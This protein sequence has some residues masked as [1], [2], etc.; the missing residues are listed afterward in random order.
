V[1]SPKYDPQETVYRGILS[2]LRQAGTLAS[3]AGGNFGSADLIYG[4]DNMR[5]RKF[6]NSLRLRYAMRMGDRNA[7][8]ARTEFAA[9]LA[10]PGGVFTSNADNAM[11]R[12]VASRPNNNPLNEL[13]RTRYDHTVSKTLV[14]TLQAKRDPRLMVY[15]T[16]NAAGR[17]VGAPNGVIS[18]GVPFDSLS[19]IGAYFMAPD[20]PSMLMSYSEVLLLQAEAAA[21]GWTN[22]NAAE[23]Y[24]QAIRA[25]LSHYGVAEAQIA[26][27]L[28]SPAAQYNGLRSIHL[29]KWISLFGNGV[30]AWSEWRRTNVPVLT[31]GPR[32][33][34]SRRIPA[35]FPY[36]SIEQSVNNTNRLEAITRQNPGRTAITLNEL[37]WWDVARNTNQ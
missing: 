16:P 13:F 11:L 26:T 24:R 21:R 9:A 37:V 27:Y 3:Q 29:E 32:A 1:T 30:E 25:S 22:G 8:F 14:D 35:R 28:A 10:A 19:A 6:A 18:P 12:Y 23:L 36:P 31:P 17:Y 5:W 34:N 33:G 2:E 4:G 7:E 20:A 15:A